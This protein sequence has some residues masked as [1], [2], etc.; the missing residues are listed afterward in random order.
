MTIEEIIKLLKIS[1][2]N[3][4]GKLLLMLENAT[5]EELMELRES[6]SEIIRT[7]FVDLVH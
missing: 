7:K 5:I 2:Q 1:G 3:T 6:I 4:K